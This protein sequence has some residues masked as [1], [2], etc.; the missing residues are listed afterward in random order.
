MSPL[1]ATAGWCVP[2]GER[3]NALGPDGQRVGGPTAGA[4]RG[5]HT[6]TGP[7]DPFYLPELDILRFGAFALVFCAHVLPV[8]TP[9]SSLAALFLDGLAKGGSYGVDL[10]FALSAYL[11][12]SILLRE[13]ARSGRIDVR[14]FY[15]RRILRIWPLYF[16]ALLVLAPVLHLVIPQQRM[17]LAYMT[18]F[19]FLCG[20]WACAFAGWPPSALMPLWSVSIE[21]QFYLS[22]PLLL[23]RCL[24]RHMRAA[25]LG[26]IIVANVT[27]VALVAARVP[28]EAIWCNTLARLD[29]I[30]LGALL[31]TLSCGTHVARK[32]QSRIAF[33][34]GGF[35][36]LIVIGHLGLRFGNSCVLWCYPIASLA[37]IST[38]YGTVGTRIPMDN[39]VCKILRH[40]GRISYGLYVYHLPMITLSSRFLHRH[41][42]AVAAMLTLVMALISYDYLEMPFLRLKRRFAYVPS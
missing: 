1:V 33:I 26:M 9:G 37:S 18:A 38:L 11:I 23:N 31:S 30:A 14:A 40:L 3:R 41:A 8:N 13:H 19:V 21:E 27:R 7:V 20:N 5:L 16:A 25:C 10:F 15:M 17:P 35:L 22:W 29:P 34:A 6:H 28:Y 32:P 39:P 36:S 12:T 42:A 24:V 2:A 4:L